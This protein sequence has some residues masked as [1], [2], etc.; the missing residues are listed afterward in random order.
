[1]LE[2]QDP[3]AQLLGTVPLKDAMGAVGGAMELHPR[4]IEP[5]WKATAWAAGPYASAVEAPG[6]VGERL[7]AGPPT[8]SRWD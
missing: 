3:Y 7:R 5:N 2:A 6:T 4:V 8:S 1:M